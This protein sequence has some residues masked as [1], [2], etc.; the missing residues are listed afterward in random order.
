MEVLLKRIHEEMEGRARKR[1]RVAEL[2]LSDADV[3]GSEAANAKIL[4]AVLESNTRD[5]FD[6]IPDAYWCEALVDDILKKPCISAAAVVFLPD[7][8]KTTARLEAALEESPH[9]LLAH[10]KA[11]PADFFTPAVVVK[12]LRKHRRRV[13]QLLSLVR[14]HTLDA[15]FWQAAVTANWKMARYIPQEFATW[16]IMVQALADAGED[17]ARVVANLPLRFRCKALR[18]AVSLLRE[19]DVLCPDWEAVEALEPKDAVGKE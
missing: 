2:S 10:V 5:I 14:S 19:G 4:R 6:K 9:M 7:R 8:F 3:P 11:V 12:L 16:R 15:E 18:E 17:D 1:Q 13:R